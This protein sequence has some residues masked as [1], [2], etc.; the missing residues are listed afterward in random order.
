MPYLNLTSN[1]TFVYY[2]NIRKIALDGS[3]KQVVS[4]GTLEMYNIILL[5]HIFVSIDLKEMDGKDIFEFYIQE[6]YLNANPYIS[7]KPGD[8]TTAGD[9]ATADV[10]FKNESIPGVS[11]HLLR[12]GG[13]WKIDTTSFHH[14]AEKA[15]VDMAANSG[16]G[17]DNFHEFLHKS[18]HNDNGYEFR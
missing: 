3:W 1:K 18:V 4:Q 9:V 7:F 2:E 13:Q 5:R 15:I 11:Y 12:E 16:F 8:F 10:V 17:L 14:L 6:G